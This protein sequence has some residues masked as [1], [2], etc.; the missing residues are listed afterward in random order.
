MEFGR[1]TCLRF[2]AGIE[3][4]AEVGGNGFNFTRL[5]ALSSAT[6]HSPQHWLSHHHSICNAAT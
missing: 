4:H 3:Q 6:F 5:C 2:A 1:S